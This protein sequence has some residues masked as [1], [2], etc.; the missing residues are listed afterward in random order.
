MAMMNTRS[1]DAELLEPQPQGLGV[2]DETRVLADEEVEGDEREPDGDDGEDPPADPIRRRGEEL[3]SCYTRPAVDLKLVKVVVV[4]C[5][6]RR[7][8]RPFMT[9]TSVVVSSGLASRVLAKAGW[10]ATDDRGDLDDHWSITIRVVGYLA[11]YVD[12]TSSA[13]FPREQKS[14]DDT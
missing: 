11:G 7:G 13:R 5:R 4:R 10:V 2:R 12:V 3:H 8:G 14:E 6:S 1:E 9:S